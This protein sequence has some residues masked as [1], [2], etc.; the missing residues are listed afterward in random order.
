MKGKGRRKILRGVPALERLNPKPRSTDEWQE[1][2]DLMADPELLE[3]GLDG[4][5]ADEPRPRSLK[6]VEPKEE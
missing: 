2:T 5:I 6:A 1:E 4:I 3:D